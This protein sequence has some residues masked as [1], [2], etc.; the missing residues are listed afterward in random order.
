[1]GTLSGI[2]VNDTHIIDPVYTDL[3]GSMDDGIRREQDAHMGD[4]AFLIIKKSQV[5]A[6]RFLQKTHYFSFFCLLIGISRQADIEKNGTPA[7]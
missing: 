6:N 1:M 4:P 2:R 7:A 3:T 5:A